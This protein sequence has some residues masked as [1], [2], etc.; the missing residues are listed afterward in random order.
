LLPY[1]SQALRASS[2]L[3][4]LR[5]SPRGEPSVGALLVW[6]MASQV[7]IAIDL[8]I[9]IKATKKILPAKCR[10]DFLIFKS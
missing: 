6:E 8:Q 7:G 5:T 1:P 10:H 2:A 3:H 9:A 4:G